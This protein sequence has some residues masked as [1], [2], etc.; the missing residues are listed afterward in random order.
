MRPSFSPFFSVYCWHIGVFVF[1][2]CE[3]EMCVY[4]IPTALCTTP[5]AF[6]RVFVLLLYK[7]T[8]KRFGYNDTKL[9]LISI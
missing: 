7:W 3:K 9:P 2:M 4:W 1:V 5:S 6:G 8:L